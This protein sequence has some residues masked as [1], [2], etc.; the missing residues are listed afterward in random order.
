[1]AE[2]SYLR[3]INNAGHGR[4]GMKAEKKTAKRLKAQPSKFSGAKPNDRAD[5]TREQFLIELKTTLGDTMSVRL[6]WLLKIQAEAVS[7]SKVPALHF[8]FITGDGKPRSGGSY[9][10]IRE[11][12][13]A[14]LAGWK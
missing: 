3:R 10:A 14:E 2:N 12:D 13:F 4:S 6:E 5:M 8:Q 1:M 11:E 9:I 7:A